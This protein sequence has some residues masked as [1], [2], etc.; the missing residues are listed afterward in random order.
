MTRRTAFGLVVILTIVSMLAACGPTP[1]PQ[2][3]VQTVEVEKTVVETVEVEVQPTRPAGETIRIGGVGPLSAPGSVVGGIAMQFAMNLAV[4]DINAEGGVL[5]KPLEL[6]FADTE[7]LPERGAAAAERLITENGVVAITGEYHSAVGLAELE[8][9]H[10]YGIPC[11]FSETWSDGITESG[12]MEVFRIAPASSMNSRATAEWFAAVGVENVVSIVENTDYGIGQDEADQGFYEELGINSQEV[13]FVELGTEDF[14]PILTRI[15]ALSPVPDAIRVAVTGETSFNLE[16]QMAELGI[17]PSE[18]TIGTANQVAIQ[19]EFWESVPNG[20]YYVFSLV[21]LPPSLYNDTTTHVAEAYRAQFDS[22]P[23]SYALEA[24]DSIWIL[25]DAIERAGT[26]EPAALIDAL[27]DTDITLAQGR[28][29]FEYTSKNPIPDDGSVPAYMWHQWPDPAV[30]LLQ[31]FEPGQN[32]QD[33]AVVWP[34]VYQTHGTAYIPYEEK[35]AAAVPPPAPPEGET[36]R[37]GGVGPLSAPG[38]VVGGIAMQFAMNL[39]VDDINAEGGVLGKPL[40]LIFGDTEGLPERGGAVAERLIAE[41]GVVA[42]TGEYHSAVGLVEL[43]VCHEYGIPCLFSETWSDGITE[44]GYMEVFRIAP[45]SSMNSRATAE[46]FAAVGVENVVS[47]VENTDYG[48]GQDEADQGFY[49]E[50]GINSQEV[51]FVELGTEDFLPIL[52]RIQALSPVPD[53]IR[54]AVTGETSFNLEQQMAELGIAPSEDTIGT[55]N[56]VAIQPEFWESVPNGTYYVFSLVGLPP[57][58][59]NDTTTHVAEAYRAQFDSDPPSYALEAYDSIWILA[60]A[61]ERAGTTEPTALIDALEDTDITLAQGRYYFEY[62]SKN[63]LPDD[64]SVPAYMWHQ[65]P[66]PA[67]LLLQYFE[68]NQDWKDAA[69]IWPEVYQT[70]G[71]TY[72]VPGTTP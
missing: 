63:P 8:V 37:I 64:G 23:P 1:E 16:Q 43:E 48:I 57:S 18:D 29:Y 33:A 9:C 46:W 60:D 27:E 21:G 2:T 30:L 69:V 15:Q 13:F 40:E 34:E 3:I 12:Y 65:W 19:P 45:A 58:L 39:A 26:T 28:Y 61:I 41:N 22:D 47:I 67:V 14:L 32:W 35:P 7:G 56:Q 70:H 50:L 10:E 68:P 53:A 62:T 42:I 59:Y 51:F 49:E 66:D 55:A 20:T 5:G 24:Y 52:T 36:I 6:I 38:S 54:V 44:S 72:I 4:S 17:A 25:A 71:T 11:L 31:Y